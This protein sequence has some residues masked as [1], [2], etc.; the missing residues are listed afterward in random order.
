MAGIELVVTD[1]DG[2]LW[3]EER[4]VHPRVLHAWHELDRL[5]IPI[6][7]A[8]GR[9]VASMQVPLSSFGWRPP[10]VAL[11]GA[12]GVDLKTRQRFHRCVFDSK[13]AGEVL[14][15]FRERLLEPCVYV[16]HPS[17]DVL[18]SDRP[19][20]HPDHLADLGEHVAVADLEEVVS[21]LSVLAFGVLGRPL[22]CLEPLAAD[23]KGRASTTLQA[24]FNYG[25][26]GITVV[27]AGLSK[28]AGVLSY[29]AFSGIS[30]DRVLAIGD[31]PNDVELLEN[32]ACSVSLEGSHPSALDVATHVVSPVEDGGWAE[33]L[34][35]LDG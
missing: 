13:Q 4:E 19:S 3:R 10:I 21:S 22:G 23:L 18:V 31:G 24:S 30:S 14:A 1:L 26:A 11:D 6:L 29:C 35:L 5:G 20:T 2:T 28:W 15:A 16:D 17:F 32:A 34:S 12:I 33:L 7:A 27:P 25:A 9:R 8:S